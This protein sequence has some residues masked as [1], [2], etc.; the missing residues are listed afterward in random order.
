MRH[1]IKLA[2]AVSSLPLIYI[3]SVWTEVF[4]ESR[5]QRHCIGSLSIAGAVP[6]CEPHARDGDAAWPG[7]CWVGAARHGPSSTTTTLGGKRHLAHTSCRSTRPSEPMQ[8]RATGQSSCPSGEAWQVSLDLGTI[9]PWSRVVERAST[10]GRTRSE[11]RRFSDPRVCDDGRSNLSIESHRFRLILYSKICRANDRSANIPV[12]A[13]C[14]AQ[15]SLACVRRMRP[16]DGDH[17]LMN[18]CFRASRAQFQTTFL[19]KLPHFN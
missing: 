15:C 5:H 18:E 8:T 13:R 19:E 6:C 2:S 14:T 7:L 4:D 16:S 1:Q 12:Q 11:R 9:D 17:A 3:P 10:D